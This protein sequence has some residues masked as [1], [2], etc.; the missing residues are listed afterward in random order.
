MKFSNGKNTL[1]KDSPGTLPDVSLAMLNWF[2]KITFIRIVKTVVAHRV[3]ETPTP[4]T[5]E[6]VMQPFS[7][8]QIEMKPEGQ[9]AWKWWKLHAQPSFIVDVDE[10]VTYKGQ[11]YRVKAQ[12]DYAEYGYLEYDLIEDYIGSG[13]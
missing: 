3:V 5:F 12:N 4:V 7:A 2:Q 1:L 6:G 10:V 11:N 8:K 13:P 9:R